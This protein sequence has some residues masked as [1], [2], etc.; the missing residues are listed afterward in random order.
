MEEEQKIEE[1]PVETPAEA[2]VEAPAEEAPVEEKPEEAPVEEK[3]AEE[4]GG[5]CGG[6]APAEEKSDC[7]G[8]CG[9]A[10]VEEA[11]VEE[12]S[13]ECCAESCTEETKS[14]EDMI[15]DVVN[16][17][18]VKKTEEKVDAETA[19]ELLAKLEELAKKV[20]GIC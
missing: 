12:K 15:R 16:L 9:E 11:P 19:D 14:A 13:E 1:A 17:I 7:G 3:P 6:E 20:G 10:P 18:N 8:C 4:C 2:P 5:C